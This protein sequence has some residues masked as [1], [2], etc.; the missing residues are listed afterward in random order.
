MGHF[1]H[2]VFIFAMFTAT[3]KGSLFNFRY[4]KY[5][6]TV[7]KNKSNNPFGQMIELEEKYVS[8]PLDHFDPLVKGSLKQRYI[9]IND[10]WKKPDGPV[11]LFIGG[12]G[13]LSGYY[14]RYGLINEIAKT[15]GA[16]IVGAEHRYYGDSLNGDSM[17]LSNLKYLSSQQ[18]LGDL[19]K[20]H[21][22][23][24]EEYGVD[25]NTTWICFG[26]SYAGD[27]SAWFRIKYPHLVHAAVASSAPV[28]AIT[29][30]EGYNNVVRASLSDTSI[31]GSQKC[32][33]NIS[34]G[35]EEVGQLL[36]N[37]SLDR[38]H[39]DFE[40]C[41]PLKSENDY[42]TFLSNLEDNISGAVQYN[43]D[44][45]NNSVE[46]IC[47]TIAEAEGSPYDKLV[48]L[49]QVFL[50]SL[51]E[52]CLESSYEQMLQELNKTVAQ[53]LVGIR[54]W[55][56]QTCTQFGFFQTCDVNTQCPFSTYLGLGLY[57]D[58]CN[59]VF[60]ITADEI[61][62][63]V[64]FTNQYY[65]SDTPKGT[66]ILFVNGSIDPWH[67]LSVLKN[68]SDSA[69]TALYI[70]G[71]S[72]CADMEATSPDD[73]PQLTQGKLEIKKQVSNWLSSS[74]QQRLTFK[75]IR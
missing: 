57:L 54:P 4:K 30:F 39:K 31:G 33:G 20:L 47:K 53:E 12:E 42:A 72:H 59:D 40:L 10:Y 25:S 32:T 51:D 45:T 66:R 18:A 19:A 29:N 65:G 37:K 68:I 11:F 27:L 73:T 9:V 58:I 22:V 8:Q 70:Q 74:G 50:G 63:R 71:S 17:E 36:K 49:N 28:R 69:E 62:A 44:G 23:I 5:M 46:Y 61:N 52:K 38:L 1:L 35:F 56:Y 55:T 67:S 15:H 48:H 60:G 26:G 6:K 21:Q 24:S 75:L 7:Y 64:N 3:I 13:L 43:D 14:L 16:L 2:L 41:S 34:S